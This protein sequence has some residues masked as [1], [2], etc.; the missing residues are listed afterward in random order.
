MDYIFINP[1]VDKMYV[2][3]ELNYILS[4]NNYERINVNNDWHGIVKEKYKEAIDGTNL[5]VLDRRCPLAVEKIEKY[6]DKTKVLI[7]EIEPILIHCGIEIANREDLKGK[8]KVITTPCESLAK[9]GNKL[10]LNETVFIS[11]KEFLNTLDGKEDLKYKAI[12][13][14]PIPLGYFDS[15]EVK[16]KK[17]TGRDNIN[18]CFKGNLYFENDIVEMLYCNNGCNN[19]DGVLIDE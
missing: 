8:R 17:L 3:D 2:A 11:W 14:S 18:G 4:K 9:H 1:V 19:G 13:K 10:G 16:T 15:L 5:T 12:D 6:L 7:P